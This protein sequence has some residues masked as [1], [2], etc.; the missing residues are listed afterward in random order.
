MDKIRMPKKL[1]KKWIKALESGEYKQTQNTV[2]NPQ[3]CGF[4]CLGVL[5]HVASGGGCEVNLYTGNFIASPSREWY[6]QNKI[7]MPKGTETKLMERN[8]GISEFG[9]TRKPHSFKRI[10]AYLRKNVESF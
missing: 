10:A 5:Q 9:D 4:C 7:E 3:T 6:K 2:Y 1:F 8:D